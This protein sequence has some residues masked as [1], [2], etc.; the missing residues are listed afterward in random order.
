MK[1]YKVNYLFIFEVEPAN[2][3]TFYQLYSLA[4]LMS[5]IFNSCYIAQ[6]ICFTFYWQIPNQSK[7]PVLILTL[8]FLLGIMFNPFKIFHPKGRIEILRT[9]GTIAIAP[10]GVVRF[11]HFFL[12][13]VITSA[14][15]MLADN[16]AMICFYTSG[17][18]TNA[19][20]TS[21]MW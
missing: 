2:Q 21:C 20:P 14:K 4:L 5:I 12:A 3:V 10:F 15:L 8:I 18:F 1:H 6:L 17:D 13:D 9:L 16:D 19:Q 7:V 11:R